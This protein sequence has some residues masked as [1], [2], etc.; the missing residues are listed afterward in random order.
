M[1]KRNGQVLL[2]EFLE[3]KPDSL[4]VGDFDL[5]KDLESGVYYSSNREY[6]NKIYSSLGIPYRFVKDF[7]GFAR[8]Y[9]KLFFS[10]I[11]INN[12]SLY[13]SKDKNKSLVV[14]YSNLS[15]DNYQYLVKTIEEYINSYSWDDVLYYFEDDLTSDDSVLLRC[16]ESFMIVRFSM[17]RE[18]V[19]IYEGE[20]CDD[21]GLYLISS[22]LFSLSDPEFKSDFCLPKYDDVFNFQVR[23]LFKHLY[24]E[25]SVDE[26]LQ[27]LK[28]LGVVLGQKKIK[29]IDAFLSIIPQTDDFDLLSF[30]QFSDSLSRKKTPSGVRVIDI[31]K[32]FY[33]Y[34]FTDENISINDIYWFYIKVLKDDFNLI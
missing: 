22:S 19:E 18:N 33:S 27:V 25:L 23:D 12:L 32:V 29:N 5:V 10:M 28:S 14:A 26:L 6:F 8:D 2:K 21:G 31:F 9:A 3:K 4:I 7:Y 30:I 34:L 24:C 17:V 1:K 16:R 11:S 15:Y 13:I 20:I